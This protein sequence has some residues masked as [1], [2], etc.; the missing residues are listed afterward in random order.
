M[1]KVSVRRA[2]LSEIAAI[3]ALSSAASA[4]LTD[5]FGSGHWSKV[6]ARKTLRKAVGDR[7]LYVIEKGRQL[8]GTFRLSDKKIGFY[9]KAWFSWPQDPA[10]YLRDMAVHPAHQRRGIGRQAMKA[11]ERHAGREGLRAVRFDAYEG[12][13]GAGSFYR[14]CG[15]SLVQR[16]TINGVPL[17]Y[18]EKT[19]PG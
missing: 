9:R 8:V 6:T 19:L 11:I 13:A 14:K 4:D 18:Y 7:T 1:A 2:E 3:H 15:Y 16:G 5:R 17:E 12:G 10:G